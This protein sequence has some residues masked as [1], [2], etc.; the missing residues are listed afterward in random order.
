MWF[1]VYCCQRGFCELC[2]RAI[3]LIYLCL[4]LF[5]YLGFSVFIFFGL[6]V[7]CFGWYVDLD[8]VCVCA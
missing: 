8:V 7:G 3:L 4:V 5:A 2:G 1:G 6:V